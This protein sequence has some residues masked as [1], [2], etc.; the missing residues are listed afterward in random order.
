MAFEW[1][2][3]W[4]DVSLWEHLIPRNWGMAKLQRRHSQLAPEYE[5]SVRCGAERW[6]SKRTAFPLT[7]GEQAESGFPRIAGHFPDATLRRVARNCPRALWCA[8]GIGNHLLVKSQSR[9]CRP[10]DRD[11]SP[12][13]RLNICHG[14]QYGPR[15]SDMFSWGLIEVKCHHLVVDMKN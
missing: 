14:V 10:Q 9:P 6:A 5:S 15:L 4:G 11:W 1:S 8:H 3:C 12:R 2:A 13:S 7:S